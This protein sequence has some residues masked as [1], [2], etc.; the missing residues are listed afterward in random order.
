MKRFLGFLKAGTLLAALLMAAAGTGYA[1]ME[2]RTLDMT[3]MVGSFFFDNDDVYDDDNPIYTFGL[4]YLFTRNLGAEFT[5]NFVDTKK[6]ENGEP[7]DNLVEFIYKI[8]LLYHFMPDNQWVPYV[9][10]G[11]GATTINEAREDKTGGLAD[12]GFG[13]KYFFSEGF[14][15]RIDARYN[16]AFDDE[17]HNFNVSAGL[18]YVLGVPFMK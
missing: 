11:G 16:Y 3:G 8:D 14:A 2:A 10:L 5:A 18:T 7:Y 12:A 4:G 6:L 1:Q 17:S 9:A 15:F 13:V